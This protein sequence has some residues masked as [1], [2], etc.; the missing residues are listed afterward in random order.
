MEGN[1]RIEFAYTWTGEKLSKK[2][3]ENNTLLST[4]HY[5]GAF[6]H[7]GTQVNQ[8]MSSEGRIVRE[9]NATTQQ[10]QYIPEHHLKDHLG[11][12]RLTFRP[13]TEELYLA[14]METENNSVE[15]RQ[16][17]NLDTRVT[18]TAANETNNG[19]EAARLNNT[20]PV[21]P[22]IMLPVVKNDVI[23]LETYAYFEGGSGY[24]NLISESNMVNAV[25]AAYGGAS[26]GSEQSIQTYNAFN[27]VFTNIGVAG[28]GSNIHQPPISI[29]FCLIQIIITW[30]QVGNKFPPMPASI[31]RRSVLHPLLLKSQAIFMCM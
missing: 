23:E 25:A 3:Y 28:T 2:V 24:N 18:S 27:S 4:S 8:I 26:T 14:T 15:S 22:A 13:G 17:A 9:N 31:D 5:L 6:L 12:T 21:G 10:V 29:I 7:D 16:F 20:K 11:N 19:N 1:K 30:R